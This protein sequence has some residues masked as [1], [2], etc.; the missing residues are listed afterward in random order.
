MFSKAM[1]TKYCVLHGNGNSG[2]QKK[3]KWTNIEGP[4]DAKKEQEFIKRIHVR[5]PVVKGIIP[6]RFSNLE[7]EVAEVLPKC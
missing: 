2:A 3:E 7:A 1:F 5:V 4:K 6:V